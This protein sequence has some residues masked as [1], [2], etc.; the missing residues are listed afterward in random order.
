M[1][2]FSKIECSRQKKA[3]WKIIDAIKKSQNNPGFLK[4]NLNYL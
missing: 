2:F 3:I 1:V 4:L